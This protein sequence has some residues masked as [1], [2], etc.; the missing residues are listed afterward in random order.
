MNIGITIHATDL[1]INIVELAREAEAR[2]FYSLYIPEHTHIPVSRLT[3]APTGEE[4]LG[5]E[6]KRS[7]DPYTALAAAASATKR[8][9]LG[10]GVALVAQ[11]HPITLAKQLA[12]LDLLSN[13][14]L[15]VGIGYGWNREE[16]EH[17]GVKMKQRRAL[18][19]E[20]VLAMQALWSEEEAEFKGSFV[21]FEKSWQWPKPLQSPRPPILIGGGAGP[22]LFAHI[23]E[24]A[25]GWIPIGGSGLA[26]ALP[27]LR[28]AMEER[29]RDPGQLRIVP[30]GVLPDRG[31]MDYYHEIGCTEIVLRLPSQSRDQVLPLLDRFAEYL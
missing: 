16:M 22:R 5:E 18:V 15:V 31:K 8:I 6:Y 2:G 28:Q 27:L 11:H 24:Y 4:V 17:H 3:P 23:A 7:L 25:D 19:R 26:A 29:D 21:N 30:M 1:A 9:L 10:T 13:G 12:T 14:R 20:N